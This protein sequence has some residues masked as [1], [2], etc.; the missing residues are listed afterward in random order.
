MGRL[1][2]L[3][4][5]TGM[6]PRLRAQRLCESARV[7]TKSSGYMVSL[8]AHL[9]EVH[10]AIGPYHQDFLFLSSSMWTLCATALGGKICAVAAY[11]SARVAASV[12]L[13]VLEVSLAPTTALHKNV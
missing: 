7:L 4:P 1:A 9:V 10:T 8:S 2:A 12:R 13:I 5:S 11:K 6:V 3:R